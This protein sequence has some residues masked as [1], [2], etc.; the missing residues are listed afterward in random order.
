MFKNSHYIK[1]NIKLSWPIA[2]NALLMQGM[3]MIDTLLVSP[4]GG[5]ALASIGIAG[6]IVSL[7]LGIQN[8]LAS[9]TQ[10]ILSRAVGSDQVS[11]IAKSYISGVVINCIAA[12]VFFTVLVMTK[13]RII[14]LLCQD[15]ELYD[16]IDAYLSVLQYAILLTALSQVSIALFNAMGK[17]KIPMLSYLL[18]MPINAG[19]SYLLTY[20]YGSFAGLGILGAA[21]G[22]VFALGLRTLFLLVLVAHRREQCFDLASMTGMPR[23]VAMHFKE[24]FPIAANMMVLALG[25]TTYNFLYT[26]LPIEVY[27]AIVL[28][29][30]WLSALSQFVLA[31]AVSSAITISQAIGANK[32]ETLGADVDLS[33]KM[34]VVVSAAVALLSLVLSLVVEWV[35]PG[36]SQ[37][38]YDALK[39]IAPLYIVM[40]LIQGYITAHGQILRALGKTKAVFN[41]NFVTRWVIAIPLF[42]FAILVLKASIFWVYLITVLEQVIKIPSMR[43]QARK[44]LSELNHDR[45]RELMY[46]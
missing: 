18:T 29:T 45:A 43:S 26:Q 14:E 16:D 1:K 35:Y 2:I 23:N 6:T 39:T 19:V 25:L 30:P 46:D 21:L 17:T 32:L 15:P 44:F 34:T 7:L 33:I 28:I 31:W 22:S 27:A 37:V 5:G 40:P 3:F 10:N 42:A 36:Q 38:T 13:H 20:G 12:V 9:G 8:A 41:I 4:L 11:L 24:T